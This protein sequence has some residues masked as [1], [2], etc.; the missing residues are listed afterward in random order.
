ME[1]ENGQ[2]ISNSEEKAENVQSYNFSVAVVWTAGWVSL[3]ACVSC[4]SAACAMYVCVCRSVTARLLAERWHAA[5]PS[6]FIAQRGARRQTINSWPQ[7]CQTLA[8]I[9]N[10]LVKGSLINLH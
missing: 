9:Q 8:D 5:A 10:F 3:L 2:V 4:R 1:N 6:K 7:L